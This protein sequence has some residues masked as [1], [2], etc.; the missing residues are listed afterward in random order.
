MINHCT[1]YTSTKTS[2]IQY[3]VGPKVCSNN[4]MTRMYG[5]MNLLKFPTKHFHYNSVNS[6]LHFDYRCKWILFLLFYSPNSSRAFYHRFLQTRFQEYLPPFLATHITRWP[7]RPFA[8]KFLYPR[9]Y[10]DN[11]WFIHLFRKAMRNVQS[12]EVR[13]YTFFFTFFYC[14]FVQVVLKDC[15]RYEQKMIFRACS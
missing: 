2:D 7:S 11:N 12:R 6:K 8:F 4:E 10:C 1:R 14:S 5:R 15:V 9:R 13:R 3:L